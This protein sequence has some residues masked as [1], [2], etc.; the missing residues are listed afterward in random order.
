MMKKKT[1]A[2]KSGQTATSATKTSVK[3]AKHGKSGK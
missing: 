2:A 3:K 1:M